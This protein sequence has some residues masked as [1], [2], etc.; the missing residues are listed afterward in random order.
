MFR[1]FVKDTSMLQIDCAYRN[2]RIPPEGG[3]TLG[4]ADFDKAEG[5][6]MWGAGIFFP[7]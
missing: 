4:T 1:Q 6:M 2:I 5:Q 7:G 3:I